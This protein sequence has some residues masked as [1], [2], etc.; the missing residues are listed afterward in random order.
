MWGVEYC[1]WNTLGGVACSVIIH[2]YNSAI[3][4][5][6]SRFFADIQAMLLYLLVASL[7]IPAANCDR[8]CGCERETFRFLCVLVTIFLF[9][10]VLSSGTS[11]SSSVSLTLSLSCRCS[12]SSE[13]SSSF[14]CSMNDVSAYSEQAES[15]PLNVSLK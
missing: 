7:L 1:K 9:K 6:W 11:N 8:T 12:S 4:F 3:S 13:F 5:S 10:R 2:K 15:N 14:C